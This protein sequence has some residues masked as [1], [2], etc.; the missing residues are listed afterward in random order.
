MLDG[1]AEM[2]LLKMNVTRKLSYTEGEDRDVAMTQQ[3]EDGQAKEQEDVFLSES[4]S[5]TNTEGD[6]ES[7]QNVKIQNFKAQLASEDDEEEVS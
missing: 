6:C 1:E 3:K 2:K 4:H 5:D 7:E